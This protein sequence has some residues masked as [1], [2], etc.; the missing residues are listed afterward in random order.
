M[1]FGIYPPM[2]RSP[3]TYLDEAIDENVTTIAV[4]D[5]SKLPDPPNI[6]TIGD[7]EDS[8]TIRYGGKAGNNLVSV[9]R[10]FEGAAK[11][12][13]SGTPLA[14]VLCAQHI[15][16]MQDHLVPTGVILM[17]SGALSNIPS[18]WALC[19]GNS[20][21]PDL[22]DRFILGAGNGEEPGGT[23]GAHSKTL[24]LA[25]LPSHDHNFTTGSAGAH[26]HTGRMK[27]F[28]GISEATGGWN[29]L[30]QVGG[31]D[32]YDKTCTI[33]HTNAGAHTHTGTTA[34]VGSGTAID[35]RPKYYKLAFIMKL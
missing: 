35:I 10:G 15:R 31:G 6:V 11:T 14:N 16:A 34:K 24:V 29:L 22:R 25:N 28:T 2:P 19:D 21:T 26:G 30:R 5:V 3:V 9:T 13:N 12:W 23:G 17:W 33:T 20:G 4:D 32:S 27:N 18:G 7:G 1:P 8:E